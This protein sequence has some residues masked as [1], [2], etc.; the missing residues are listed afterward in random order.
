MLSRPSLPMNIIK[1]KTWS[2]VSNSTEDFTLIFINSL[3]PHIV[4]FKKFRLGF[5]SLSLLLLLS[6]AKVNSTP[7]PRPNTI[8]VLVEL[9]HVYHITPDIFMISIVI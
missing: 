7:S 6:Q 2:S 4:P 5:L 9:P 1:N 3:S 8:K